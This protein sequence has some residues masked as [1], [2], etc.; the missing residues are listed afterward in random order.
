[1]TGLSF[2]IC[3]FFMKKLS[4]LLI[5]IGISQL[6]LGTLFLL[7]PTFFVH[8]MGLSPIATDG[9]YLLGMLSARFFVYGI[10]MFYAA[11][12]IE[13][14]VFWIRGMFYIQIIDLLVGLYYTLNGTLSIMNSGF[15][16]FNATLFAILLYLWTPKK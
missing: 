15:P 12:H 8:W 1:M 3:L 7:F 13:N 2:I 10:G 9:N 11:R 5:I 16:M 6:A 14:S 4:I